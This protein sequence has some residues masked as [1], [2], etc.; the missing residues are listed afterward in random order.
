[1]LQAILLLTPIDRPS[2]VLAT[3]RR[4]TKVTARITTAMGSLD[5]SRFTGSAPAR[6]DD[7]VTCVRVIPL[8]R[9]RPPT[10]THPSSR[11]GRACS[12]P[13]PR[14]VC[15]PLQRV[16]VVHISGKHA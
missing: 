14:S 15:W 2:D 3:T 6:A 12:P 13:S 9:T 5:D 16:P 4:Y 7:G 10:L 1:M 8:A 11:L